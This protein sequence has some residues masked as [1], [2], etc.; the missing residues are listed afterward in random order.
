[1]ILQAIN[2][3]MQAQGISWADVS[4]IAA[5]NGVGDETLIATNAEA[6][7]QN[8]YHNHTVELRGYYGYMLPTKKPDFPEWKLRVKTRRGAIIK[9]TFES[10][11]V[12][13]WETVE[14]S[15]K[16]KHKSM[17]DVEYITLQ[18]AC[19]DKAV[20]IELAKK[21]RS[22]RERADDVASDLALYG[23]G[24]V[25]YRG[26]DG[27]WDTSFWRYAEI[28]PKPVSTIVPVSLAE[29]K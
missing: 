13:L 1:M 2:E 8:S 11:I 18:N 22:G 20:F 19:V 3:N 28:I 26:Y 16:F 7:A 27:E 15:L 12:T 21:H 9:V 24:W 5:F 23:N 14:D 10:L 25:L 29:V 4:F 17:E 6:L